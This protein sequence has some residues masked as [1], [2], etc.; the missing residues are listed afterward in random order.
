LLL[1]GSGLNIMAIGQPCDEV[2]LE[3]GS[4]HGGLQ[5]EWFG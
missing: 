3:I 2:F 5:E 4:L 1:V